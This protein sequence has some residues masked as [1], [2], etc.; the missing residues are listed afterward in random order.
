MSIEKFRL[1]KN[2]DT[3]LGHLLKLV[4]KASQSQAKGVSKK[5]EYISF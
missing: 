5:S 1:D 3:R 4:V 2:G